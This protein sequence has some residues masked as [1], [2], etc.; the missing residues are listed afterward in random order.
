MTD[1]LNITE[2]SHDCPLCPR[3][4]EFRALNRQRIPHGF[5]GPVPGWGDPNAQL[6]IVGLAPGLHG[7]NTTGRPFTGDYA[8]DLLYA[9][10]LKY[11]LAEG[12]YL[13]RPDDGLTLKNSFIANAVRCVP[14]ENKPTTA[15]IH[16]CRPFLESQI[17]R[18][19]RLKVMLALGTIAHQSTIK[20]AGG[21]LPK[22]KFAHGAV[23]KL[24]SGVLLVDSYHCSRY[25]T[26]TGRLTTEMFEAV[27]EQIT[28][29]L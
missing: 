28:E 14:P 4:A 12:E 13:E 26:N 23:H 20:A 29:L 5:N 2:P 16:T 15:E 10:L 17:D 9:T 25:N 21:K 22:Y 6:L 19:P 24:P 7:A 3:L 27:F 11:G 18:L 8:G 1:K